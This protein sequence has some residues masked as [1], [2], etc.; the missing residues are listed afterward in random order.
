MKRH[1]T[2]ALPIALVASTLLATQVLAASALRA[3]NGTWKGNG[4]TITYKLNDIYMTMKDSNGTSYG[5]MLGGAKVPLKGDK[6]G[7]QI[8]LTRVAERTIEEMY[9]RKGQ[10][11]RVVKATVAPDGK[12]MTVTEADLSAGKTH[13]W[14]ATKKR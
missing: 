8:A 2:I 5:A 10:P 13:H 4:E 1:L 14:T 3:F 6:T 9:T 11:V 7:T 12:T